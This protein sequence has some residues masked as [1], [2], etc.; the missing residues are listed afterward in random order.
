MLKSTYR[1]VR[2]LIATLAVIVA[3]FLV[4]VVTIDLGPSL[5]AR[6]EMEGSK[7]IDRPMHI[8]KLGVHI[9]RGRFVI[10][11]LRIEGLTPEARPWLTAGRIDIS[12]AWKALWNREVLLDSIE[13]S[14]WK[15]VVESFPGG[16]HNWPRL[17]GPPRAPRTGPP[18]VV[19]T[20][21][22]VTATRGEFVFDDHAARWGVVAP[23]LEVTAG[24][25]AEYGGRARFH[26][27]TVHF[28][29][30]EP[31]SAS[32]STSFKV[33]DGKILLEEIELSTDGAESELTGI[34]DTARWPEMFYQ[35]KSTVHFPRMREIFFA[36]DDFSLHGDGEFAG[37]FRLFTGGRELKGNFYSPEAGLNEYRFQ[38]LEGALEWV[39]ERFEVLRA[40][41]GFYGGRM[42]FRQLMTE[43]GRPDRRGHA[44][45][46]VEYQDVDLTE[47]T[48]FLETPGL[49]LAG[50]ATG[51]NSLEWPL[52]AF[53]DRTGGGTLHVASP[54]SGRIMGRQVT[55]A[56]AARAEARGLDI[57][58]FSNHLPF[59]P[60]PLRGSVTY[61]YSGDRVNI[62]AG[63]VAT[64]DTFVTFEGQTTFSGDSARLPFHVSSA[65]WQES[66]RLLVAL[67]TAFGSPTRPVE[68]DGVGEFDGVML[69]AFRRPRIEGRFHGR[70]MRAFDVIWGDVEAD[71]VVE[72]AY[73]DVKNAVIRRGA[74]RMDVAGLF[75]L[76]FP[77]R[78]RGE[79]LN[80]KI[81]MTRRP[82]SDLL[83]AFDLEE[84]PVEGALS[85]EFQVYGPYT[86]PFGVGR[87]TLDDGVAYDERFATAS[88]GLRFEGNGVRL[89]AIELVKGRG[90]V[91][92]AAY[93]GW[94]GTY[95][96]NA[97]GRGITVESL[98]LTTFT[99]IP[100]F[101]GVLSFAADGS[102]TFAAPRYDVR[103]NVQDLF[104]GDEGIGEVSGRLS[105]RNEL[106]TFEVEAAS[107]RLAV[108]GTGRVALDD[109][110]G[111]AE[112]MF[113]V[114]D[115][116]LDPYVRVFK[117]DLSPYTTAIASGTIRVVG[118]LYNADALHVS[119]TV[120][121]LNLRLVDYRLRNQG[122]IQMAVDGPTLRLET[123]R[124]VGDDTAL[125]LAGS[126]DLPR[127]ALSLQA[128]GAANL[129]VLQGF[130]PDVRSSGRADVSALIGGTAARPIVSGQALVTQGRLRHF[131]FPHALEDLNGVVAFN[132]AG[133]RLD[134]PGYTT[135]LNGKLGGGVVKF[136]GRIGMI[137]YSPSEFDVIVTGDD[138]RLR[139]P[140][141]MRSLVDAT[142]ALQGPATAPLLTGTVTV[143][144]ASWTSGF[145]GT[146]S[147]FSTTADDTSGLPQPAGAI[148][149]APT[150]PL[151]Y[152]VRI[153]APSTLRIENDQA[154][155]V[156]STDLNLRGTFDRPLL[157]GRAEIDRGDVR[158]EGRRYQV[159]RGSLD[160]T[161]PNR[162]QPF[163]DVEAETRVRVPGQT[164]RVTLRMTGTTDRM[165]PT[166]ES[167][168]PLA[169]ID[170]LTLLFSDTAPT[171]DIE[172]ASLQQPNQREQ[173]ILQARATRALTGALSEEV[174]RVVE[175]TFGV[176][177]F[178]ITPLLM[179]PYQETSRLTVNPAARVT[180]GKRIS[181]RVY[182]TYARS[183][184]SSRLDEI[185]LLEYDQSDRLGW[186]LS[187][188]EDRTYAL[189]VRRRHVF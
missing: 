16:A 156:A 40:S 177:T 28:H 107:S 11:D 161:N 35:V 69:G 3:A 20:L 31:M 174:G 155:I 26:G 122:P 179:D 112:L 82:V 106:L 181:E 12:L 143:E 176:D 39:P 33:Q 118:D 151:R 123:M 87:M 114:S 134:D 41:S 80:A 185:I 22:H 92:G 175:Q 38:E 55:D 90:L 146:A 68:M 170:V 6:A 169:P 72:N 65:N 138:M 15:M 126:I 73:A 99:D 157:F 131:S 147:M 171:G 37:T 83:K 5:K 111:D 166:F 49:R 116:S 84:Y 23:N 71:V 77:R 94:N 120:E 34:V 1:R 46:D 32:L 8:G 74:S 57:T 136:G 86:R 24:K 27:G 141:G 62:A 19:T 187:Q 128:N 132:A 144:S 135:G 29:D 167:D 150:L 154:E 140:E 45:F 101:T 152:D 165:Q 47:F 36:D 158:F 178:Q 133:I 96:F 60:V 145:D 75:S 124:L 119:T 173:E 153:L 148:A 139:F 95:S 43:L 67:M 103:V 108:S 109:E 149:P 113:R 79:E 182:L 189:E 125:D 48:N 21:Q 183:L 44:K 9:A 76:G 102:A 59:D 63:E 104:F 163:F 130:L 172:L 160:F 168:P 105:I 97:E 25:V 186:V 53:R 64:E 51:S 121:Q 115:T 13:M 10:E 52:G 54:S 89:D 78:D 61:S 88:A 93:V 85:G 2:L 17:G 70:S 142:L 18:P 58:P 4:S 81:T 127:Q 159:T 7:F 137:G 164:Y 100:A 50:R 66:D 91:T 14:D 30:F 56:H 162:I 184:S 42:R 117:P 188:N 180:I 129:A 98:D 110:H